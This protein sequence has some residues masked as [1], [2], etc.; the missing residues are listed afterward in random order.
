MLAYK[1]EILV[2]IMQRAQTAAS[3]QGKLDSAISL[4][5]AAED[6]LAAVMA[7]NPSAGSD[8]V[9]SRGEDGDRRADQR[10]GAS[11]LVP[12]MFVVAWLLTPAKFC[13][14]KQ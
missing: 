6:Q 8:D 9:G 2:E 11:R 12:C 5:Q 1:E 10:V 14:R 4:R 3:L 7:M 13:C